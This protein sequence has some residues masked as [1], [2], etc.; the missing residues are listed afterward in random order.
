MA[1]FEGL[2]YLPPISN[3]YKSHVAQGGDYQKTPAL[4]WVMMGVIGLVVGTLAFLLKQSIERL[5]EFRLEILDAA[6]E[7]SDYNLGVGWI[8]WV[9]V[10][11]VVA[12]CSSL[13]V[14]VL[15]PPASGSGIPEVMGYLNGVALPKVFNVRTLVIKFFS[16]LCSVG[17]GLPVGP[18]GPM[19]HMGAMV[20]AGITQGR[21]KTFGLTLPFLSIFRTN[22]H[23]RDF[24]QGGAAAGVSAAFGAPIGGLLFVMEEVASFWETSLTWMIFLA[25]MCSTFSID[26]LTSTMKAWVPRAMIDELKDIPFTHFPYFDRSTVSI[27]SSAYAIRINILIFIPTALIGLLGGVCGTLFTWLNVKCTRLRG[28]KIMP[29]PYRRVLEVVTVMLIYGTITFFLPFLFGCRVR[30]D[31]EQD[32]IWQELEAH[33]KGLYCQ[34]DWLGREQW[35]PM[36]RLMVSTGDDVVKTLI[37]RGAADPD[38][39]YLGFA[40]VIVFF[41]VYFFGACYSAGTS[42]SSGLVVPMLIIGAAMGRFVGLLWGEM[43]THAKIEQ[44]GMK[45]QAVDW[46]DP[47][48]F[49]LIGA[50]SFFGGVSRLTVS[51]T[52]IMLEI[53][54]SLQHII[55][56]M[57][58]IMIAKWVADFCTHSLYHALLEVK[59]VP[60]LDYDS[61]VPKMECFTVESIMSPELVSLPARPTV[62]QVLQL[63]NN[64]RHGAFPVLSKSGKMI[65]VVLRHELE[66]LLMNPTQPPTSYTEYIAMEDKYFFKRGAA[67]EIHEGLETDSQ[68]ANVELDLRDVVNTSPFT[69]QT[70]FT[71]RFTYSLFRALGL[72]HLW[73][74][75]PGGQVVGVITRKD[76]LGQNIA[77]KIEGKLPT[78]YEVADD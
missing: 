25:C 64:H 11:C 28:A 32:E 54:N 6:L 33:N 56:M 22:Q 53:S 17:S 69:V 71:L 49:A 68:T 27:F 3:L 46:H 52:V 45:C 78:S 1:K 2:D 40:E 62:G 21:S 59:C 42:I 43:W 31:A 15:M 16:C 58:S 12:A 51:L 10:S 61:V 7:G 63:L 47:G 76:L 26:A 57:F 55:P 70:G 36:S 9:G 13:L 44:D 67:T 50:A 66:A 20:G 38:G 18:E 72:R 24:I 74:V 8:S 34:R 65:G 48:I 77:N 14:V 41:F 30:E 29:Y 60:F 39:Y 75:S 73:V 5:G 19:I 35:N 23:H 4:K 37:R